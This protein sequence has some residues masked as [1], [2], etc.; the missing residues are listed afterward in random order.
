MVVLVSY[1]NE[2]DSITY[3]GPKVATTLFVD[4]LPSKADN[5][6]GGIWPKLLIQACQFYLQRR[7]RPNQNEVA[8]VAATFYYKS[9]GYFF[10]TLRVR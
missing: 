8:K 7:K 1:K 2:E 3:E 9:M 5:S 10:S 4:F 6:A